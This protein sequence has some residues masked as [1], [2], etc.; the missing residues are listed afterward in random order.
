MF[1]RCWL[2]ASSSQELNS[3]FGIETKVCEGLELSTTEIYFLLF[4]LEG[5][6]GLITVDH[7]TSE[8]PPSHSIHLCLFKNKQGPPCAIPAIAFATRNLQWGDMGATRSTECCKKG[9]QAWC[10][11]SFRCCSVCWDVPLCFLSS[12]FYGFLEMVGLVLLAF[13]A[14]CGARSASPAC[15]WLCERGLSTA[16]GS[17]S[18]QRGVC[19]PP[20]PLS[21][22]WKLCGSF[23]LSWALTPGQTEESWPHPTVL[24]CNEI[25]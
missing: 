5:A 10:L 20:L 4:M 17:G 12:S 11:Q 25:L 2:K 1:F 6:P 14:G 18:Q 7:A 19:A 21:L 3:S 24:S 23:T 13:L 15:S 8:P 22:G 9:L 16:K